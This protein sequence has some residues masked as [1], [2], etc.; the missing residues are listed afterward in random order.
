MAKMTITVGLPASGK[1]TWAKQQ[2][3]FRIN[4][5]DMTKE[6]PSRSFKEVRK[7]SFVILEEMAKDG[8][9]VIIDNTNLNPDTAAEWAMRGMELGYE[10]HLK[11]FDTPLSDC[12]TRDRA[13]KE[14]RVGRAVIE[15][16]ALKAGMLEWPTHKVAIFDMDGTISDSSKRVGYVREKPKDWNRFFREVSL[17]APNEGPLA[18]AQAVAESKNLGLVIVSGRPTD[19]AGIATEDWLTK[20]LVL[21]YEHLFM[22]NRGDSR[23]DTV[24]KKEILD[25][26]GPERVAFAVD[27]RPCVVRMWREAGVRCFPVGKGVEF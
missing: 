17:D 22:R 27:D 3:G 20:H 24:V 4:W 12:L 10:V 9:D 11:K 1:T 2:E 8:V 26:I 14:G 25:A 15:G 21:P 18:W 7:Q 19:K 16:M 13:R 23:P 6:F 5:D